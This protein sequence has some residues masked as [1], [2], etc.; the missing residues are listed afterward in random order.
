MIKYTIYSALAANF[1][2]MLPTYQ[3]FI[4]SRKKDVS[5]RITTGRESYDQAESY[6]D[7]EETKVRYIGFK[8][9]PDPVRAISDEQ[10]RYE[11]YKNVE[12]NFFNRKPF[13]CLFC[14]T[15]WL[16][17]FTIGLSF[18]L[19]LPF[20]VDSVPALFCAPVLAVAFR[21]WFDSLGVNL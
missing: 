4:S 13:T 12:T 11:F 21:R 14:L 6:F 5:L 3:R 20:A 8:G 9:E 15:F 7:M 10:R 1:I 17:L 16:S 2:W 19:S 18:I